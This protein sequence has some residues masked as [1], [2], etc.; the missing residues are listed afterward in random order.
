MASDLILGAACSGRDGKFFT[1]YIQSGE[2]QNKVTPRNV[3]LSIR[4]FDGIEI[5]KEK[6]DT[7]KKEGGLDLWRIGDSCLL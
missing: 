2:N 3:F 7:S 1:I 5:K 6:L 4:D